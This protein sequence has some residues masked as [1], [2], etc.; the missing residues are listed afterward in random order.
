MFYSKFGTRYS[1]K[2]AS[3][4]TKVKNGQ[5]GAKYDGYYADCC[6]IRDNTTKLFSPLFGDLKKLSYSCAD[7][8]N[9]LRYQ[10]CSRT[11]TV[12]TDSSIGDDLQFG[13]H[14]KVCTSRP[15]LKIYKMAVISMIIE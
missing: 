7:T 8:P 10:T 3:S 2:L 6:T 14:I 11:T 5:W 13:G 12:S 1:S 15:P 9:S 4:L